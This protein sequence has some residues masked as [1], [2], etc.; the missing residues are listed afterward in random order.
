MLFSSERLLMEQETLDILEY[1]KI[2]VML[3]ARAGSILGKERALAVMPSG[4]FDEVS[5]RLS[6][7]EEAVR[8]SAVAAPPFGGVFDIRVSLDKAEHGAVLELEDFVDIMST[9]QAMRAVKQFFKALELDTPILKEQAKNIEILGQVERRLESSIDEHGNLLDDASMELLRIRRELR[10]GRRRV[11]EQMEA[12]LHRTEYQKFFQDTIVT[13]RGGR[14]VVPIKQEYR[15]NFPGI[16]HDQ[17]ASGAT[18]FIEPMALVDLNN[19]LKQLALSERNE[20]QRIQRLL[21]EEIGK[22]GAVLRE[23]CMILASL[24]FIFSR[25]KL[26]AD[27]KA[28]KPEINREGRTKL[29]G[30]RHPLLDAEKVV[31]IDIILGEKYRMLLVTGPNTGGKTV[32]IKTL[33][34]LALMAQSGCY[35]PTAA[36]SEISIYQNVYTVIGDEQSIEQSLSTF[37]AHMSHIVRLLD[38][39]EREDLLLMDEIGAGTD[40]EEG[41]ALAMAVLEQFLER[42]TSTIVTTHYSELKTFAFTREGIENACVEFDVETLRPTYR[43]LIGIPGASNAFA[44]SRRLGL[45]E[46]AILRARQF[47]N[48]DHAQFER[49]VNQLER[50]RLMYE[51][52]NADIFERQQR[53]AR[54]EEKNKIL[55]E[56]L[57]RQKEQILK[58]AR[59]ESAALVRRT[60]R[61]TEDIIKKLKEQ[62]HEQGIQ[63]RQRAIQDARDVLQEAA[64]RLRLG[65]TSGRAYQEKIDAEKL[66]IGD[67]VY[68]RKLDQKGTVLSIQG[69]NIGIQLGSLKMN[70]KISDCRFVEKADK[71]KDAGKGTGSRKQGRGAVDLLQKTVDLHREIDVRGLMVDEAEKVLDKFLDDAVIGGLGQVLIIHGKGTGALRMGLHAYLKNHKNV[72]RFNFAD[73]DEGGTGATLVDLQ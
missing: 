12:I 18:L 43:L 71:A 51:E 2:R 27:M 66:K 32:G 69:A 65:L 46:T 36:N 9:L 58:N 42:G 49:V 54:L 6:E 40:P 52:K 3:K 31:P 39:V 57:T 33:G 15:Q 25:A 10:S 19:E 20:M 48:A 21:S 60:R 56:E 64:A 53:V 22:N 41:A 37:S 30:A 38:R 62:F 17:S 5:R 67:V 63:K 23:N 55:R 73:M 13:Q 72:L 45:P 16:V 24:D 26:A 8:I 1:E 28:T 70:V 61:E 29:M 14:N 59:R 47:I 44:I 50:E 11:K 7:T 4:D 68:V 35:L 34:L